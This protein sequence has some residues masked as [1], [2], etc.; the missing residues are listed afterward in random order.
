[1]AIYIGTDQNDTLFGTS[2]DDSIYGGAGD[3]SLVG[4]AG[5]DLL[6]GG[7]GNDTLVAPVSGNFTVNGGDGDDTVL[8]NMLADG[9]GG[10][11]TG[12]VGRQTYVFESVLY[13]SHPIITD[14][15]AGASGD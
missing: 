14:F 4:T 15:K 2:E 7:T 8:L 6:D 10:T 1:M 5:N 11:I 3:D 12:G 13:Q 9:Y